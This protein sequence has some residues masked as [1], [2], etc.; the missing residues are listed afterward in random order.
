VKKIRWGILGTGSIATLFATG[1]Q[2]LEDAELAAVGSRS[3]EAA[4]AFGA[5]FGAA[6]HHA[7]Y[8]DLA[9]D[10]DVDIVYIA[11]PHPL[12]HANTHLCLEAGKAVLC[13]KPFTLNAAQARDLVNLARERQLF[14][15]EAMWTRFLPAL[16]EVRRLI[17]E[18]E[19]GDL[20]FLTVDFGF[21]K[22]FDPRHRLFDRQLGGGAL[23]DVGVYLASL[24]SMLFGPP[25]QIRSLAQIGPTGV[26]EQMALLFGYDG[27]RFAQLTA[28][29]TT[30]TPQEATIVGAAGSITLHPLWWKASRLTLATNGR[31]PQI[32]DA[33]FQG[34]GYC[35]EAAEAMRC[36]RA[37]ALES[38]V[39]PLDETVAV[40]ETLDRVRA[41]WGLR[42]PQE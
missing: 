13:E 33:P 39:M 9:A 18:G 38:P 27:G 14:L 36:L 16:T 42:Y 15:M 20:R 2:A 23:L 3:A 10:P 40:I 12:H 21:H 7:S 30:A 32:I 26:D 24:A 1:L 34:N 37:G 22:E 41:E 25:A 35:H 28:S 11:T 31:E 29:I 5:R 17:N 4:A 6:R 8:A 19:I